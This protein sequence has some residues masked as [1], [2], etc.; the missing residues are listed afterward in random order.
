MKMWIFLAL[1]G[2]Y[3]S[4]RS[5]GQELVWHWVPNPLLNNSS[6]PQ[7]I[8]SAVYTDPDNPI[9][10]IAIDMNGD[11]TVDFDFRARAIGPVVV[12]IVPLGTNE[13]LSIGLGAAPFERDGV[14]GPELPQDAAWLRRIDAPVYSIGSAILGC[15]GP[16]DCIPSPFGDQQHYVGVRFWAA[17]GLHYGVLD[18]RGLRYAAAA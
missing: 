4:A 10:S 8:G 17:D 15:L 14:V 11:G 12:E 1:W 3:S 7:R 9:R 6:L 18:V 13:V 5:S 2:C 16:G